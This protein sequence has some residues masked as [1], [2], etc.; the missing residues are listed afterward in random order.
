M[1]ERYGRILCS[2]PSDA[3]VDNFAAR[4]DTRT[5]AMAEAC[6]NRVKEQGGSKHY[7]HRLVI[8]ACHPSAEVDAFN[9]LLRDPTLGDE[10]APK[11]L[12]PRWKLHLS[13]A[14]WF[15]AVLGSPAVPDLHPDDSQD[16]WDLRRQIDSTE[17][18]LERLRNVATGAITWKQYEHHGPVANKAIESYLLRLLAYADTLC[19]TPAES[20][21]VAMYRAWKTRVAR[22]IAVDE[23]ATMNRADLYCVWGNT[24]M[25]C[26]IFGDPQQLSPTVLTH[27]EKDGEGNFFN[28]FAKSGSIS[29][30]AFFQAT[31]FPVYWLTTQL[32]MANGLF[33]TMSAVIYPGVPHV[34]ASSC[35][36]SN[37]AFSAGRALESYIQEKYP[38]VGGC[39]ENKLLPVFIHTPGSRVFTYP[40]TGSKRS[41]DQVKIALD[42]LLGLV[43]AKP[44]IKPSQITILSPYAGNV[45]TLKRKLRG[46]PA[47]EALRGMPPPSTIHSFQGQ[48]NDIVVVVMGTAARNPGPGFTTQ[49]QHLN[50]MMTRH[51]CGL[52]VVGDINVAGDLLDDEG[53]RVLTGWGKAH[54]KRFMVE[55]ANGERHFASASTLRKVH[56]AFCET[57]RVI[58][59][60]VFGEETGA[61]VVEVEAGPA[62]AE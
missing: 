29:A 24:C 55:G 49:K 20:E 61:E 11:G 9:A 22:G 17:P 10:A 47:Y 44:D 32:R 58:T 3:A 53:K 54:D 60:P 59:I 23:A 52:V 46:N 39:P 27:H 38:T 7:R 48:E 8:R 42:F 51:R 16:L 57:G 15:L 30:L 19:I 12:E 1:M 26:F 25:P 14:F 62:P 31:G 5:R 43:K 33:D 21:D 28:R 18:E 41:L 45:H 34:Y 40:T 56:K 36:V 50:V 13:L 2:A 4:L 35:D 6:N 37:D